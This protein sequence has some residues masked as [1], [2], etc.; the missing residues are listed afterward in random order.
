MTAAVAAALA[1]EDGVAAE[2]AEHG[3]EGGP[4]EEERGRPWNC[5]QCDVLSEGGYCIMCGMERPKWSEEES[6]KVDGELAAT[7]NDGDGGGGEGGDLVGPDDRVIDS[8]EGAEDVQLKA[9]RVKQLAFSKRV[10]K[11]MMARPAGNE[12]AVDGESDGSVVGFLIDSGAGEMMVTEPVFKEQWGGKATQQ[13]EVVDITGHTTIA[14]GGGPVF[15]QVED[16]VTGEWKRIMLASM[17]FYAPEFATCLLSAPTACLEGADVSMKGG[18][19]RV[20]WKSEDGP[21]VSRVAMDSSKAWWLGVRIE[22]YVEGQERE[23]R[24]QWMKPTGKGPVKFGEKVSFGQARV[25]PATLNATG[26]GAK[27]TPVPLSAIEAPI[28]VDEGDSDEDV[29]GPGEGAGE[30]GIQV[31][32]REK[33]LARMKG[34]GEGAYW[35]CVCNHNNSAVKFFVDNKI[36]PAGVEIT[37]NCSSCIRAKARH[38]RFQR[39]KKKRDRKTM[40]P[41]AV[42]AVDVYGPL[43]VGDRNGFRYLVGFIC[44]ATGASFRQPVRAK[45]QAVEV[46]ESFIKWLGSVSRFIEAK[47]NYPPGHVKVHTLR[48]DRGGEFTTTLGATASEFDD[49]AARLVGT[50]LFTSANEPLSGTANIERFWGTLRDAAEASLLMSKLPRKYLF[51]ALDMAGRVYNLMPTQA[52]ALGGGRPPFATLG[53]E[54]DLSVLVPFGNRCVVRRDVGKSEM[55]NVRGRIIGIPVDTGGYRVLL[56]DGEVVTSVHVIPR[57]N[58]VLWGERDDGTFGVADE[59]EEKVVEEKVVDDELESGGGGGGGGAAQ[60]MPVVQTVGAAPGDSGSRASLMRRPRGQTVR[61]GKVMEEE[62]AIRVI[63]EA[64]AKKH[65]FVFQTDNPKQEGSAS[66]A[67]YDVYKLATTEEQWKQ[68][69]KKTIQLPD[70]RWVPVVNGTVDSRGGDMVNDMCR[71]Y[72]RVVRPVTTVHAPVAPAAASVGHTPVAPAIVPTPVAPVAASAGPPAITAASSSPVLPAPE[73]AGAPAAVEATDL[74]GAESTTA[75]AFPSSSGS[76]V[77]AGESQG[78]GSARVDSARIDSTGRG[79]KTVHV[80]V[81]RGGD[82]ERI[83]DVDPEAVAALRNFR[84]GGTKSKRRGLGPMLPRALVP[85]AVAAVKRQDGEAEAETGKTL[86]LK[87]SELAK[88]PDYQTHILPAI[89]KEIGGQQEKQTFIMVKRRRGMKPIRTMLFVVI[90]SNGK[91]KARLVALGNQTKGDGVHYDETATSMVSQTA[92]KMVVALAAGRRQKLRSVDFTQAFLNTPAPRKLYIQ[93]PELP[94]ECG[95]PTG[96]GMVGELQKCLYGLRDAPRNWQKFLRN[97]LMKAVRARVMATERNV[98]KWKWGGE[99]LLGCVH[100][101]DILYFGGDKICAEFLRILKDN[102]EVTGGE[103]PCTKFCG[104][105]FQYDDEKGTIKMHQGDFA[106]ETLRKFRMWDVTPVDTPMRVGATPLT[107]WKGPA[108]DAQVFDYGMFVGSLTWLLRTNPRLAYAAHDLSQFINNP[109]PDHIKAAQRVLAH[110]RKDPDAGLTFHGTSSVLDQSYPHQDMII[111]ASDSG[112]SHN[113]E[114]ATSGVTLLMNGAAIMHVAR[115]QTTIS[116]QSTEAEVKAIALAAEILQGVMPIWNEVMEVK[117]PPVRL[118]VD[119]KG[120]K[121]QV[122]AGADNTSSAPY[123]KCKKYAESKVYEGLMWLDYVPGE[124]NPADMATKQ[125]RSTA[126]FEEKNGVISGEKPFLFESTEIAKMKRQ[127][128]ANA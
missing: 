40:A 18:V 25:C 93:L 113:G 38:R 59:E 22:P 81:A 24:T 116:M 36:I 7:S 73:S 48:S 68:L 114:K 19:A 57:R 15:A 108:N 75:D 46:L 82:V 37:D 76:A 74:V 29:D 71:G 42:T 10:A 103:E 53:I 125:V 30:D 122:E 124:K 87:L 17:M 69:R 21:V 50:R 62:A 44:T 11:A 2:A 107:S 66:H 55:G 58:N 60:T 99:E 112:F 64:L 127:M 78:G 47:F 98:F 54:F 4:E 5:V 119:N 94:K 102:F 110:I 97:F 79:Q 23:A 92:V 35:H 27:Q 43:D 90:K 1:E 67:R 70:G 31:D 91:Y 111:A 106:R 3:E 16:A 83:W 84:D 8:G 39:S 117:H 41:F 6:P 96:G 56:E 118:M 109:G 49:A 9:G 61:T 128:M 95:L 45:S 89:M 126:E 13:I 120:A 33:D 85:A 105:Q 20:E 77:A 63:R 51:D 52:N 115:R 101:D 65:F 80:M 123:I 14:R 100:V 86:P 28:S 88:R 104:Y 72:V 34:L 12:A 121:R 32:S 26:K